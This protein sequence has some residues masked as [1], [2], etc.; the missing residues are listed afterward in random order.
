MSFIKGLW[1]NEKRNRVKGKDERGKMEGYKEKR[2]IEKCVKYF[3]LLV[4]SHTGASKTFF[5]EN[6]IFEHS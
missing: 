3:F 6:M 2:R 4:L 1:K 5:G